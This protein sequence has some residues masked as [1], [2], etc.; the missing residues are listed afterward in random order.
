MKKVLTVLG[1]IFV[2]LIVAGA[3]LFGYF[4]YTGRHLDASSKQYVDANIPP[5]V[6][7]WSEPALW[8]RASPEL[9]QGIT[10]TRMRAVFAKLKTLGPL[11]HYQGCKGQSE[12][13][14]TSRYG[15]VV[16]ADYQ[17]RAR[18]KNGNA[19]IRVRLIRHHGRWQILKFYVNSPYFLR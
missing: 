14:V 10:Q 15:K 17:A 19:D 9:R 13:S 11:E 5:I 16:L 18:F 12:T 1:G 2:V 6:S 4:A 7:A 3:A 8:A